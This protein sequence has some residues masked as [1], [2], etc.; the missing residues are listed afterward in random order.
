MNSPESTDPETQKNGH[1]ERLRKRFLG[2]DPASLGDEVLLE[3]LLS[4]AILR[5]D[6]KPLAKALL[7]KFGSLDAALAADGE[8]LSKISG[9]KESSVALLKLAQHL[10]SGRTAL[11]ETTPAALPPAA[12]PK[13]TKSTKAAKPVKSA[14]LQPQH[15]TSQPD[16]PAPTTGDSAP[17]APAAPNHRGGLYGS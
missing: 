17:P 3:L 7:E 14:D 11:P 8:S 10:R 15:Y 4:Y 5:S 12:A 9:I 2:G 13:T 6:V 16:G 1:R